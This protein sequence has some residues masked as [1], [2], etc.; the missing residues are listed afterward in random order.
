MHLSNDDAA[1]AALRLALSGVRGILLGHLSESNNE[2]GLALKT[3]GDYL[4]QNGVVVG[5][6]IAL[7]I[8]RREGITGYYAAK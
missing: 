6:H 5:R 8:A 3:V 2:Y 4:G 7:G 1:K